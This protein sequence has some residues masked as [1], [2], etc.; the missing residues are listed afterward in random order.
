M[1]NAVLGIHSNVAGDE[2]PLASGHAWLTIKVDA[3]TSF[4]GLWPDAHPD[5]IDNGKGSDIRQGLEAG[6]PVAASRYYRLSEAQYNHFLALL[7]SNA[8]WR[9]TNNCSSW[10]SQT[11]LSII[12]EDV[13]ADDLMGLETPREL[14]RNILILEGSDP[15]SAISPKPVACTPRSSSW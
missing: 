13:D 10:A 12:K 2:H 4:Y 6:S 8:A 3:A 14:G 15:T 9:Y 1:G 11:V 5:T 7:K